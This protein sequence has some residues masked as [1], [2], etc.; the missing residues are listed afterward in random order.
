MRLAT[1]TGDFAGYRKR[2][3]EEDTHLLRAPLELRIKG[4]AL[5]Y[6]IGK[7]ILTTYDCFEE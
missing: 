4:E 1:T 3:F 7:C 5:L 6:E 2:Q